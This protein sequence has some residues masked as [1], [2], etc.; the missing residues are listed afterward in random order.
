MIIDMREII[1]TSSV[2]IL[3]MI[4][5]RRLF[6]GKISSRLQYALWL[7]VA[8]RLVLPSS[9]QI[10]MAI[11]SVKEFRAMDLV[12][13]W[14]AKTGNVGERLEEPIPFTVS[15]DSPV[16]NL[17]ARWFL[18]EEL[19]LSGTTNGP[20]S[21]FLAGRMGM[22]V[23]DILRGIWVGGMIVVAL[24]IIVAN[25][26]FCR[27]LHHGRKE[28]TA[29]EGLEAGRMRVY[30][31]DGLASPCLYG[32]PGREA[33]YLTPDIVEDTG[34]L[35]HVLTHEMCHKKHGDS[36]W[37]ILRGIL[38]CVYWMNPL[39]WVAAALSKR[40]CELACDEAA[41][42]ILGDEE[43]ISYGE[44]LLSIITRRGKLADIACMAT[45][46][47]GSGRSVKERIRMIAEKPKALGAAVAAA[48]LLV[49]AVSVFVFTKSPEPGRMTWEE[50]D[51]T[52]AAGD[53]Q[54]TLPETIAG[55]SGYYVEEESGD[56]V[57]CQ[58]TSGE[59]VGRFTAL[60]YGTAVMLME[61]GREIVPLGNYGQN[62]NL[63]QYMSFLYDGFMYSSPSETTQHTYTPRDDSVTEHNYTQEEG[64]AG[65]PGTDSN[66]DETTYMIEDESWG[67]VPLEEG[68]GSTQVYEPSEDYLPNEQI[69]EVSLDYLPAEEIITVSSPADQCYIYLKADYSG[70]KEPYLEEIEYINSEL[71]N[72][73]D[74]VIVV[75]INQASRKEILASLAENK[76]EY[77]GDS[78][79]VSALVGALPCP[80]GLAYHNITLHTGG[81]QPLA[82]DIHYGTVT[83]N[84]ENIDSDTLF[85]NAAMLFAT[86][87]NLEQCNLVMDDDAGTVYNEMEITQGTAPEGETQGMLGHYETVK[88]TGICYERADFEEIFGPLWSEEAA[89]ESSSYVVWLEDLFGQV[90]EYLK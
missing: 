73:A 51:L 5:I 89:G 1:V 84:M 86:I 49:M 79:K 74:R 54:V 56:L 69:E 16:G 25:I 23:I 81:T 42:L 11:G 65:V 48:L 31:M 19:E 38:L 27:K 55:I 20:T 35:R 64:V 47:T 68:E 61:E 12:K 9:A 45:T 77:L 22:S 28:F 7:L 15:L 57:V 40:D 72:N 14:E 53:M 88:M 26:I 85:F 32:L 17:V 10:G 52:V 6:K 46:M 78:S 34:R 18:Q 90:M 36:F 58:T 75:S 30:V 70:I 87:R 67:V 33:V 39:V 13:L 37:S 29:P 8:L 44:T 4:L 83:D 50:G 59:E 43:R 66:D 62:P 63:K 21:V 71:E 82:L 24:W 2:L 60:S 3:C 80:D 76:T 41:L